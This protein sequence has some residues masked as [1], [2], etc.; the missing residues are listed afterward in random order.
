VDWWIQMNEWM[1]E[2]MNYTSLR[3]L[4]RRQLCGRA[5]GVRATDKTRRGC[6]KATEVEQWHSLTAAGTLAGPLAKNV[7]LRERSRGHDEEGDGEVSVTS[8]L[9][10][11]CHATWMS[12]ARTL[13][14]HSHCCP[15]ESSLIQSF[16]LIIRR[17]FYGDTLLFPA[18]RNEGRLF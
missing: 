12:V 10:V 2:W 18:K 17:L 14:A 9:Q 7:V 3:L 8:E 15:C 1:N 4:S 11:S 5:A 13:D 6:A 16:G